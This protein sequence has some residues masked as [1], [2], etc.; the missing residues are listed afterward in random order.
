MFELN[1]ILPWHHRRHH[2]GKKG[3][4]GIS[5]RKFSKIVRPVLNPSDDT[6]D[7]TK[8]IGSLLVLIETAYNGCWKHRYALE[9]ISCHGC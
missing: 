7:G 6:N 5:C 1:W 4:Y 8:V 9:V 3:N 2:I